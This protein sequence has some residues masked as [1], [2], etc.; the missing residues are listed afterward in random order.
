LAPPH[1]ST[2]VVSWALPIGGNHDDH[3]QTNQ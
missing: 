2:P 3:Y 1:T